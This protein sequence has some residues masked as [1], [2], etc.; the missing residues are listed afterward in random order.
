LPGCHTYDDAPDAVSVTVEPAQI[1]AEE[2]VAVT[3]GNAFTFTVAVS[4]LAHPLASVPVT[5]YVVVTDGLTEA[6]ESVKLPGIH[7]YDAAPLAVR[8]VLLPTQTEVLDAVIVTVGDGFTVTVSTEV[9]VQL[10]PA[11]PVT[12]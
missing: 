2:A 6:E 12:V 11:V 9:L 7:V 10:F 5:V 3:L 4:V 1:D 8:V